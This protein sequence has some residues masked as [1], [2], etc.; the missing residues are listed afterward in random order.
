VVPATSSL[1][2]VTWLSTATTPSTAEGTLS[3]LKARDRGHLRLQVMLVPGRDT[4]SLPAWVVH[5]TRVGH[6]LIAG[7]GRADG[8]RGIG[9]PRS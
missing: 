8:P 7:I 6:N 1:A 9:W 4:P 5:H 3:S 2:Q